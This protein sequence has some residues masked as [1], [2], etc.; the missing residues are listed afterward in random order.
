MFTSFL[1]PALIGGIGVSL[2]A[3]PLGVF[4]LWRRL[5]FLGEA[6]AHAAI[7]GIALALM[8]QLPV[9]LGVFGTA[10]LLGFLLARAGHGQALD[11]WLGVLAYSALA[12]GLV[13]SSFL[14]NQRLD[15][16]AF[17]FGDILAVAWTDVILIWLGFLGIGAV[18]AW[19]WQPLLIATFSPELSYAEG[20][21]PKREELILLL[22]LALFVAF[23]IQV[24][25]ALLIA[26]FLVIPPSAAR[27]LAKSPEAMAL[28]SSAIGAASVVMGLWVSVAYDT[29]T[30]PTIVV[31]AALCFVISVLLKP[32]VI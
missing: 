24:V 20:G 8:A 9:M 27:N 15:L 25:G 32:R 10:M 28:Y 18:L 29:P 16:F 4:V 14:E 7:L 22:A 5:A 12:I 1:F 23:A 11:S 30:S 3:G 17:L 6:I 2:A 21:D 31:C 13:V 19:R 26:A